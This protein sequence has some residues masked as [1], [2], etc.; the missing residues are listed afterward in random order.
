[1]ILERT[2][3]NPFYLEEFTR[4][5]IDSG[6]VVTNGTDVPVEDISPIASYYASV[7]RRTADGEVF[8]ADQRMTREEAL[9]SY[10][11]W[12]AYAAFEEHLKGQLLPGMLADITVLSQDILTVPEEQI[13]ETQ[14]DFTIIG[15]EVRYRR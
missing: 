2:E 4:S 6:A 10:T 1:M 7:S 14:I 5:L 13:L 12:A 15:G 11:T 3:G 9:R 8:F